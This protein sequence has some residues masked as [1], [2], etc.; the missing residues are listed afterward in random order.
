[1]CIAKNKVQT[2]Q[3]QSSAFFIVPTS[4]NSPRSW[5]GQKSQCVQQISHLTIALHTLISTFLGVLLFRNMIPY[6]T[7][8]MFLLIAR[9]IKRLFK[10]SQRSGLDG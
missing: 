8:V 7:D 3:R 4:V 10:R 5:A 2:G 1:M 6:H 9:A